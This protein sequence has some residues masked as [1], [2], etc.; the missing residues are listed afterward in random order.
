MNETETSISAIPSEETV[1]NALRAVLD[2]EVGMNIVDLGLVR[3]IRLA[4]GE[5][6]IDLGLTTPACP[7]GEMLVDEV[8]D[9]VSSM[10]QRGDRINVNVL[11]DFVWDPG[12]MSP[13]AR[14]AFGW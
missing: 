7:M 10:A 4:P 12:L 1:R 11:E 3:A 13:S 8:L 6:E 14:A 2:P 9:C 5:V